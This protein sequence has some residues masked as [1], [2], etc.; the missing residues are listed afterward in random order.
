M[1]NQ[2]LTADQFIHDLVVTTRKA[3][4]Q[5]DIPKKDR[6][7]A[8]LVVAMAFGA[9]LNGPDSPAM[10]VLRQLCGDNG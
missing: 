1:A 7:K 10:T 4:A 3:V 2:F 6:P 8:C 9:G 5:S